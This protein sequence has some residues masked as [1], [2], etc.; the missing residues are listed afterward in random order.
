MGFKLQ[1]NKLYPL[2]GFIIKND[3]LFPIDLKILK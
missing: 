1:I 3:I 2:E